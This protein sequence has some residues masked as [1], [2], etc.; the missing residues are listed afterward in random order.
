MFGCRSRAA[1]SFEQ[2]AFLRFPAPCNASIDDFQCY[3]VTQNRIEGP[4]G[5]S[6]SA[7]T[8][9]VKTAV[10]VPHNL[11]MIKTA[12]VEQVLQRRFGLHCPAQQA[13]RATLIVFQG[14]VRDAAVWAPVLPLAL[15]AWKDCF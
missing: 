5:D 2:K 11:V 10:V 14:R 15:G 1:A 4:I 3:E 8:Q 12:L 13:H 9:F 7:P 6:H